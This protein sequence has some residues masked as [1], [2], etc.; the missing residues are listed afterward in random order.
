VTLWNERDA[1]TRA[2]LLIALGISPPALFESCQGM[3]RL[4]AELASVAAKLDGDARAAVQS[5]LTFV[6]ATTTSPRADPQARLWLEK[7]REIFRD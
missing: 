4:H 1:A 3:E 7:A 6:E 2:K 5:F